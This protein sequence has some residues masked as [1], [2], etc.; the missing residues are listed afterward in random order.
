MNGEPKQIDKNWK[1]NQTQ[2]SRHEVLRHGHQGYAKITKHVPEI[3]DCS[4]TCP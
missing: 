1:K 4:K 2:S 3:S